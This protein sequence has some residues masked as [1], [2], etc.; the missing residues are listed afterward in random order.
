M[1][2]ISVE[3][4]HPQLPRMRPISV[5]T[6]H[7][8]LP[9]MRPISVFSNYREYSACPKI[10]QRLMCQY[11][12]SEKGYQMTM[13]ILLAFDSIEIELARKRNVQKKSIFAKLF[14][15]NDKIR[16]IYEYT[17]ASDSSRIPTSIETNV[18]MR[19]FME[20]MAVLHPKENAEDAISYFKSPRIENGMYMFRFRAQVDSGRSMTRLETK[21]HL[22]NTFSMIPRG[23]NVGMYDIF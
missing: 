3:T 4:R 10:E 9:R 20:L 6:R 7:P 17:I 11:K 23:F 5:E 12:W 13:A 15:Y 14:R 8:Q 18:V 19:T 21:N 22:K 1:R 16:P 2:P